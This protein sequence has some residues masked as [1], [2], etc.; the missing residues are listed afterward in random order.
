MGKS[1]SIL[2]FIVLSIS[3]GC[4]FNA[5]PRKTIAPSMTWENLQLRK[6]ASQ[7]GIPQS[8]LSRLNMRELITD[9]QIRISETDGFYGEL[10]SEEEK[11][12]IKELLY[13]EEKILNKL[14]SYDL[15][16][17]RVNDNQIIIIKEQ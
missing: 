9:I 2:L 14:D 11:V 6:I 15:F 4:C 8:R 10:L 5:Q 7:L 13:G 3:S 12:L 1:S 16:I 17:G